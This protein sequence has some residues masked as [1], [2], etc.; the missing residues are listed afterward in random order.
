[1][2]GDHEAE[3]AWFKVSGSVPLLSM[4]A[5]RAADQILDALVHGDA[6]VVL[7]LSGRLLARLHAAAPGLM[8]DA[9]GL[10]GR[11]LPSSRGGSTV[12]KRGRLAGRSACRGSSPRSPTPPPCGTTSV[13]Q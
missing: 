4:G 1:M 13:S 11:L 7:S 9:L 2:K 3:Y 10:V 8:Q 6:E 5:E 12:N